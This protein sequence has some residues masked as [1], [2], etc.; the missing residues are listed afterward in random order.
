MN[1][2]FP[3]RRKFNKMSSLALLGT[4]G[5]LSASLPSE[6]AN[7]AD[8]QISENNSVVPIS[9]NQ[10]IWILTVPNPSFQETLAQKELLRGLEQL[11]PAKNIRMGELSVPDEGKD[12]VIFSLMVEPKT[13]LHTQAYIMQAEKS[14]S[15]LIKISIIAA[16]PQALLYAVYD[17]LER[18][19]AFFGLDG[20]TYPLDKKAMMLLPPDQSPWQA[21]PRFGVRGLVPWPDFLNCITVFNEEE[22]R[23]YLENMLRMRFNMLGIHVYTGANQWAESFLSFEYGGV[24]HLSF[25]DTSATHRWGYIPQ[26]TSRYG[27]SGAQFYD[28]EV[29]GS[30][31]TTRGRNCW[32]AAELAQGIWRE[33]FR[34]AEKLGIETGVGFEP[35][36]VP[37]EIFRAV[38]P[39]ALAEKKENQRPSGRIDPDSVAAKDILECRLAQLLEAYPSVKYVWL[40]ED[41]GMS[42]DSQKNNVPL[43]LTPFKQTHD[44][45]RRHAPDKRLVIS[46]WGGVAR[47]FERFHQELPRDIIFSCLSDNLGWDPT[48]EVFGKLE[49]RDRWPVPWLE[50]D[51]GMWLPQFHVHR[52]ERDMNLAEQ[53][54]CTGLLGIHWR[55]RIMDINTGYQARFSWNKDDVPAR[56]FQEYGNALVRTTRAE[57]F[58]HLM[59]DMDKNRLIL[60]SFTGEIKDGH[61]Q[62]QAF[63]G[64]YSEAFT[65]WSNNKISDEVLNSQKAVAQTLRE[66]TDK[67]DSLKEKERLEYLTKHIEFLSPFAE[68]WRLAMEIH[69]N[70]QEALK[71]KRAGQ[72]EQA[73]TLVQSS[74]VPLWISLAYKTREALLDIQRIVSDRNDLGT[75]AS[76]HNKFERLALIRLRL[77][78]KEFLGELPESVEEV[79][80][81]VTRPDTDAKPRLFIPTRPGMLERGKQVRIFAVAPGPQEVASVD[82]YFKPAGRESWESKRMELSGRRTFVGYLGPIED[83]I[84]LYEYYAEVTFAGSDIEPPL[85]APL[86]APKYVYKLTII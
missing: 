15:A 69:K 84:S 70:L 67:A 32:E 86:E 34:Y 12:T 30:D 37:D 2:N 26:K 10:Q 7:A 64:D 71:L 40:W 41:E 65:F 82:L 77:S 16:S 14:N 38:P 11:F 78:I 44:F 74:C 43:S 39:E 61:H 59:T 9:E 68:S 57:K 62:V 45:L 35:Y 8:F 75:L 1:H 19:G 24:G 49:D 23:T 60:D 21:K 3:N 20:E 55:H 47:H 81:Y 63:S 80:R 5:L 48:Y 72:L 58:A 31:A 79:F 6:K 29:F 51:P 66:L 56:Y 76:M 85:T 4:S 28:S 18:Q 17:F 13:F 25:T 50:D 22:H 83:D 33:S 27:M 46:G 73:K 53:Y 36:Q 52:F 54:G 42:W